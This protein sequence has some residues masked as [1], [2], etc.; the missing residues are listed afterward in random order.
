MFL[1][2]RNQGL[3]YFGREPIAPYPRYAWEFQFTLS[4]ECTM[5]VRQSGVTKTERLIGPVLSV[6]GPECVH[7][8]A[9]KP[10]D[11]CS[12]MIFHF[13][14][15]DF[16]VR[17]I[18]SQTGYRNLRFAQSEIPALQALYDRCAEARRAIGTTPPEVKKRAGLFEPLIYRIVATELTLFFLKH[19]PKSEL[20]PAPNFGESKVSEA[21]AWYE[22]NLAKSPSIAEVARAIHLSSTHLRR[23][24]HKIRGVSPQ[25]AFTHVQFERVKWLMRDPE[26]TLERIGENSGFGS[27]SAFSR[28]FKAEFGVSPKQF[29]EGLQKKGKPG[30]GSQARG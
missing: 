6:T 28:A 22:A 8:W 25:S 18:V 16:T 26:M 20:G 3:R 17:T 10:E 5:Q 19:I 2:Y 30:S 27:A 14:E 4:G 9:G 23:L 15:A 12:S 13:D 21:L 7:G 24:F 29:R 1:L 11:E